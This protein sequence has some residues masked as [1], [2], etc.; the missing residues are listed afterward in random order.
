MLHFLAD[1][2][3]S[4]MELGSPQTL[5]PTENLY[6]VAHTLAEILESLPSRHPFPV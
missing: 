2:A 3:H 6:I 4:R 5:N 1:P